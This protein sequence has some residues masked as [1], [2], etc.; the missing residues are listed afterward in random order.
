MSESSF[1]SQQSSAPHQ[2]SGVEARIA[3][4]ANRLVLG[5]A[6][7]WLALFNIAWGTYVF[8]PFLAPV[9][10]QMGLTL[11]A[12]GIYLVYSFLCHQ[13]PDHSF[14]LFGA[15][16]V[17]HLHELEAAGMAPGLDL[18]GQRRFIGSL[19]AGYKVALCQRDL[20]IYGS[21]LA[22]GLVYAMFR[23][24]IKSPSIKVYI[25]LV[26]PMA[27]DGLTQMFGLR[28]SNWFLRSVTGA[29][30]GAASVWIAYPYVDEAMQDVIES[31]E[32]RMADVVPA[33]PS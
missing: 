3:R 33:E 23:N 16:A 28:E 19:E 1:R 11:P 20:A 27:I 7:H 15:N 14:F 30:F 31:E 6:R 29:L 4:F 13:L 5:I 8:L 10:M 2:P 12:R 26:I 32:K 22:A 18:L 17:P 21:V 25:L 9:F 24:R